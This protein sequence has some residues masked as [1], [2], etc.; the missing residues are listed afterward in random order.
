MPP[1][2]KQPAARHREPRRLRIVPSSRR[3]FESQVGP[4]IVRVG[5]SSAT[6]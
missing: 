2:Q 3:L 6:R 5:P 1:V 4:E